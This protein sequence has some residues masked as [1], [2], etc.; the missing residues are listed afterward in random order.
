MQGSCLLSGAHCVIANGYLLS[1]GSLHSSAASPHIK[2]AVILYHWVVLTWLVWF[3][4][5]Y[6]GFCFFFLCFTLPDLEIVH[7]RGSVP[8]KGRVLTYLQSY[9]HSYTPLYIA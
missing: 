2:V 9:F 5:I 1:G 3:S 6:Q 4:I 8:L 7:Q